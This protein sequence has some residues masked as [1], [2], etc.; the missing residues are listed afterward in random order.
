MARFG[1]LRR[2]SMRL[3]D[4]LDGFHHAHPAYGFAVVKGV[5]LEGVHGRLSYALTNTS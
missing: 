5:Q 3:G 1:L 2:S 4:A